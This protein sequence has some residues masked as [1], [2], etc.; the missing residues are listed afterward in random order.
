MKKDT[1]N[2]PAYVTDEK[3]FDYWI[4]PIET[5]LRAEARGFIGPLLTGSAPNSATTRDDCGERA[6]ANTV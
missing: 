3:H 4:D 1:T 6:S 2:T 5:E